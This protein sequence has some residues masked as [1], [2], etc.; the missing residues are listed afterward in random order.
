VSRLEEGRVPLQPAAHPLHELHEPGEL[1]R[2]GQVV[3]HA[4]TQHKKNDKRD[5]Q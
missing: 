4:C 2:L 5:E 1:H 3:V